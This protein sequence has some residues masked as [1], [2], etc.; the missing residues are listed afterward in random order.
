MENG[1]K[2]KV[3]RHTHLSKTLAIPRLV[4]KDKSAGIKVK[5]SYKTRLHAQNCELK[6]A[7]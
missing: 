6:A 1:K 3:R 5:I 4:C 7:H 2:K